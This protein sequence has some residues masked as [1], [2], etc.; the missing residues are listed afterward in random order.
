M[1]DI[2]ERLQDVAAIIQKEYGRVAGAA[3]LSE[4]A[5]DTITALRALNTELV[6]G[7]K[8]A[9]E[10]VNS[11]ASYASDYFKEKWDLEADL[12]RIDALIAKAEGR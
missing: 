7:L 9:R 6:E 8:E 12:A 11:W 10:D 5:A 3:C 2:V 4:E 1:S